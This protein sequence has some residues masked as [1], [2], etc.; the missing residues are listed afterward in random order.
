M[1]GNRSRRPDPTWR[2]S[3]GSR[4]ERATKRHNLIPTP[5][6]GIRKSRYTRTSMDDLYRDYILEHYRSPHNFGV[7]EDA[8]ASFEGA[9]PLCG[10]R[11]TLMLGVNDGIVD[12]VALLRARLRDQPGQREP[13]DRRDQGQAAGRGGRDPSRRP[14]RPAR[15]R[16]QPGAPQV[17]DAQPRQP[18]ARARR[19]RRGR[20]RADGRPTSPAGATD[21]VQPRPRRPGH[22]P[23]RAPLQVSAAGLTPAR[24]RPPGPP[25]H[26]DRP[27]GRPPTTPKRHDPR[28]DLRP[29]PRP[30]TEPVA[31]LSNIGA[32]NPHAKV[33]RRPPSRGPR[34]D[35]RSQPP[36]G[37]CP[38]RRPA[39]PSSTS[40]RR[41][42]G[43][44]ATCRAPS[45]SPSPTSSSRS[46]ASRPTVTPR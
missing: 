21:R 39:P 8:D 34:A 35:P 45:T 38:R 31:S 11:I 37:R 6:V 33:L 17:R 46:R 26:R 32:P 40:A 2:R 44:R 15:H 12:R 42:N 28:H 10:D 22:D 20:R 41:P 9:N 36:G 29:T 16:H 19:P 43:S 13:P 18:P 30:G 14:A 25:D 23:E 24:H 4:P 5:M 27:E 3:R 1:A 7:I